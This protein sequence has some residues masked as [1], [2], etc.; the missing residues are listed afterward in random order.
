MSFRLKIV[1]LILAAISSFKP[2]ANCQSKTVI[3]STTVD[4]RKWAEQRFAKDKVPP[5]SFVYGGKCSD[6]FIGTWQHRTQKL[7]S[8]DPNIEK[9]LFTYSDKNGAL[10]VKC[11]V[12]CFTDFQAV[13]WVLK[14]SNTS[15]GNTPFLQD[16]QVVDQEFNTIREGLFTLHHIRGS[17]GG[18]DD[19]KPMEDSLKIGKTVRLTPAGGRSSDDSAFPFFNIKSSMSSGFIVAIGWTGKWYADIC[20]KSENL[21]SLKAGMEIMKLVIYPQEEIRTPAVCILFW[22]GGEPMTGHNQF[23]K[24]VIKHKTRRTSVQL[25]LAASLSPNFPSPCNGFFGCLSDS[26]AFSKIARLKQYDMVPEVCWMDA[27][28][29]QGGGDNWQITGNWMAEKKRFPDGLKPVSDAVHAM[30]A[31]FLLWFEP[32]RVVDGTQLAVEHQSWLLKLQGNKK[33]SYTGKKDFIFNLGDQ[34]ARLWLTDYIS[35][36]LKKEGVDYFRQDFNMDPQNY[37][38]ANDLPGRTGMTEIRYIEGLYAF[39]DALL[40]RFPDLIIDNC[41]SGGR[42]IDLETISRSS[43]LWRSDYNMDEP[44]GLQNHTYGLNFYL[45][46]HG[47]GNLLYTPYDFRSSLSSNMVLFWDITGSVV[48]IAQMQKCMGDFKRF[49]PFYCGDYYPLTGSENLLRHDVWLAYQLNRPEQQDGIVLAF[50]RKNCPDESIQVH[51]GGLNKTEDYELVDQDS[52]KKF[53]LK[54]EELMNGIK[55]SLAE[56]QQSLLISYKQMTKLRMN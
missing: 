15:S 16:V 18:M 34:S 22:N 38:N 9:S 43:P 7:K 51:L 52:G 5:F 3:L 47:T 10:I 19:F 37:W 54:G 49:R 27:G 25:P 24:F 2:V 32:E 55:L 36:F 50:R 4:V 20:Q 45:P 28:W 44:D 33:N 13:E 6:S 30:G 41:A 48:P 35:D 8:S 23:R 42:R 40:E 26:F 17:K 56:Q 46:F 14:F 1:I 12:T 39:W 53:T 21:L 29:Y 11:F 31:K